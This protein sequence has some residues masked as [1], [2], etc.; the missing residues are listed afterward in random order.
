MVTLRPYDRADRD[1]VQRA[2]LLFYQRVHGFD[3]SFAEVLAGVL[4]LLDTKRT[5][6]ASTYLIAQSAKGPAGSIFLSR[7]GPSEGRIRLFFLDEAQRGRGIGAGMLRAV[8]AQARRNNLSRI[9]VSTFD[10]HPEACQLY[11]AF[12]FEETAVTPTKAF[13]QEMRQLDFE[14]TL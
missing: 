10:R 7:E 12:G 6:T 14:L 13:G 9:K 1:W 3:A 4:D 8:L 5:E 2:N 11:D